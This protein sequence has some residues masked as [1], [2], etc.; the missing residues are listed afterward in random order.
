MKLDIFEDFLVLSSLVT[1]I[2]LPQ[3]AESGKMHSRV[4]KNVVLV[5]FGGQSHYQPPM[6]TCSVNIHG[7]MVHAWFLFV[8]DYTGLVYSTLYS[9]HQF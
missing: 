5:F 1:F 3:V 4:A 6:F 2:F 8:L 7:P 9:Y